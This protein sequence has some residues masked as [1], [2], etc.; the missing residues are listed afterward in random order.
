MIHDH[1]ANAGRYR[2]I[3][4]RIAAAL[5]YLETFDESTPD[6][7]Y[8][9]EG[10]DVFARPHSYTTEPEDRRRWETH[11]R[12]VDVQYLVSGRERIYH[13]PATQLSGALPYDPEKDVVHYAGPA[14]EVSDLVLRAGEFAVFFQDDAHKPSVAVDEREPVRK[15][16]VKV[17]LGPAAPSA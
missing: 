16:V 8:D 14:G 11:R 4:P 17:D 5:R 15:I 9:L 2:A 10:D 13:A 7:R 6:G 3:H 1:I 12:Y